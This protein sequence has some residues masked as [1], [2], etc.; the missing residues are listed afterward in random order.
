MAEQD[1]TIHT[2]EI[3]VLRYTFA[4]SSKLQALVGNLIKSDVNHPPI[5]FGSNRR[6]YVDQTDLIR[7]NTRLHHDEHIFKT[8]RIHP[9]LDDTMPLPEVQNDKTIVRLAPIDS[10]AFNELTHPLTLWPQRLPQD[11]TNENGYFVILPTIHLVDESR[12][13]EIM[14]EYAEQSQ[15]KS[16]LPAF[17]M[18]RVG[19]SIGKMRIPYEDTPKMKARWR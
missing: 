10:Q 14:A 1:S 4:P 7:N 6:A 18:K 2:R 19:I 12:Q 5:L 8:A 9:Y 15:Q 3:E 17:M 13:I 11:E 16:S